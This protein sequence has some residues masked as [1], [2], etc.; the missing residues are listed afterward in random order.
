MK[1]ELTEVKTLGE[2]IEE[3]AAHTEE[4]F[5]AGPPMVQ[6]QQMMPLTQIIEGQNHRSEYER[7][8]E[9]AESIS[10][11][12][13]LQP[14]LVRPM[15]D[16]YEVVFGFRRLRAA[17]LLNWSQV[18]VEVRDLNEPQVA[19]V[20]IA[21]NLQRDSIKPLDQARG[22]KRLQDAAG[23][24][25][26]QLAQRTGKSRSWV[27]SRLNLLKLC[28][29]AQTALADGRLPESV[30]IPMSRIVTHKLQVRALEYILKRGE[31]FTAR[32]AIAYLQKD[33]C[34]SLKGATFDRKDEMLVEGAGACLTCPKRSSSQNEPGLFEDLD[35]DVCTDT[36]C[37]AQKEKATW[38]AKAARF[39]E[40]GIKVL[41]LSEG[42]KALKYGE[43]Y[44]TKYVPADVAIQTD[45][46]R[47]TW[48]EILEKLD[49]ENRPALFV[50]ADDRMKP[51]KLYLEDQ[52][53]AAAAEAKV[54]WAVK[55][56]KNIE[57]V[58]PTTPGGKKAYEDETARREVRVAVAAETIFRAAR[59]IERSDGFTLPVMRFIAAAVEVSHGADARQYLDF[60][61][62][63]EAKVEKW[64]EKNA[65]KE[66]LLAFIFSALVRPSVWDEYGDD[67]KAISKHFGVDMVALA[68]EF[69]ERKNSKKQ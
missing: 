67:M 52:A 26:D 58:T 46:K 3:I 53:F 55:K 60:K 42:S 12:G 44:G 34:C 49:P 10:R 25:T 7:I 27:Y 54:P 35:P 30:A 64:I 39:E 5:A 17:K 56:L 62:V 43:K 28:N 11:S 23:Y 57:K 29:E 31:D 1:T 4:H 36:T 38:D 48:A 22:Y 19:E 33:F 37:Y 41:S 59:E 40:K 47:R 18:P 63:T 50:A 69:S 14:I 66:E 15:G 20:Q 2:Q 65:T 21:E 61:K 6:S 13:M 68:V 24:S 8:D 9:L 51:V 45:E 32:E 16:L